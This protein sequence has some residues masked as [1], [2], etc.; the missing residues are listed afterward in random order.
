MSAPLSRA[1]GGVRLAAWLNL[2]FTG[3]D[4]F[5]DVAAVPLI[6]ASDEASRG[7]VDRE[8]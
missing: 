7:R 6:V 3:T 8:L 5:G 1:V 4:G 2:I